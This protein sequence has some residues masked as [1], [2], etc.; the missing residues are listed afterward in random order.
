MLHQKE[1]P[2][3]SVC[4]SRLAHKNSSWGCAAPPQ[5]T[6]LQNDVVECFFEAGCDSLCHKRL[7][8]ADL[9]AA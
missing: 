2:S 6:C 9:C 7:M 4:A 1:V 5:K 3:D 8:S